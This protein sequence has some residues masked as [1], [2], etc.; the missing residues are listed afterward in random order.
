MFIENGLKVIEF[1]VCFGDLEI[2]VVFLCM[3]FDL[4]QVF[5]DFLDDK[6]VDLR[7]KDIVVVS[8]VFVLEGYLESY[9]KGMLIG[10]FVVEIEQ[11]VV[12]YVGMKVEGGEFVI[13]G[14]CVVNVMVFDELFEVVRD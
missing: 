4:V 7:W 9:V 3:E 10:S 5:F 14:G 11:V 13:N 1:N 6:E 12:F 8:V 2:Q